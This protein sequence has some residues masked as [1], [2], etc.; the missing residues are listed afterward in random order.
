M[1]SDLTPTAELLQK[2][3]RRQPPRT[4]IIAMALAGAVAIGGVGFAVGRVTA[5]TPT[6]QGFRGGGNG[7]PGG[8]GDGQGNGQGGGLRFGGFGG[9]LQ[10]TVD[11]ISGDTI[12]L[13]T[14]NGSTLTVNLSGSTTYGKQVA[15][16]KSDIA[17]GNTVRVGISFTAGQNPASGSVNATSVTLVTP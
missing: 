17:V 1:T 6:F 14:A 4:A 16:Q 11:S 5:P 10:G 2:S 13:K 9:G 8:I 7:F 3:S 12:T 15:G